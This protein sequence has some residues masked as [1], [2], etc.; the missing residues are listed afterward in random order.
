MTIN[1][2]YF[3][4]QKKPLVSLIL[5]PIW[6]LISQGKHVSAFFNETIPWVT[7]TPT[8]L[9]R[10]PSR[11]WKPC[12]GRIHIWCGSQLCVCLTAT[13]TPKWPLFVIPFNCLI[14]KEGQLSS[15]YNQNIFFLR[16]AGSSCFTTDHEC[17]RS[18]WALCLFII[19]IQI[20]IKPSIS[21]FVI[22]IFNLFKKS[23]WNLT[24]G[25]FFS[26]QLSTI[27]FLNPC[28]QHQFK[29][30]IG[31]EKIIMLLPFPRYVRNKKDEKINV[32][33]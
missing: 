28:T 27:Q 32:T 14:F 8:S 17:L 16:F 19:S 1:C 31:D 4:N 9:P 24:C 33:I 29:F 18:L 30:F 10:L 7:Y 2:P 23:S 20:N 6:N 21:L 11:P 5:P 25:F 12:Y 13:L 15:F 26:L 22:A 3:Q